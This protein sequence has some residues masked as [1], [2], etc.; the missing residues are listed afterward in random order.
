MYS[1]VICVLSTR[2]DVFGNAVVDLPV[3]LNS[4]PDK[5]PAA[6]VLNSS[7]WPLTFW[8]IVARPTKYILNLSL[9]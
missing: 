3:D 5:V 2:E 6:T 4:N 8:S 1:E 9:M 7:S